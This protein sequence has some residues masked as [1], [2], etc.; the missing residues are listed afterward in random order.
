M[1]YR[2]L[3]A[4]E[5]V[6]KDGE[7][8]VRGAKLRTVLGLLVLH[9]NQPVSNDALVD[10]LW[11]DTPPPS[12]VTTLQTYIYQLRKTLG[13]D[14]IRTR[15]TGYSLEAAR[16]DVDALRFED[17]VR[18]VPP[19][20]DANPRDVAERLTEA[21]GW[22]RGSALADFDGAKWARAG[23]TQLDLLRLDATE[24]LI[25]ARLALGDHLA[26]A[27]ELEGLI[28]RNPLRERFYAQL[29]LAL[30]R[31]DRQADALRA[32]ARLNRLLRSELGL[33]PSRE[34]TTLE[35]AVLA[36]APELDLPSAPEVADQPPSREHRPPSRRGRRAALV[37][38][39]AVAA[40]AAVVSSV[41]I[42][43]DG[44]PNAAA[45]EPLGY[46]PRYHAIR[47][48]VALTPIDIR[49]DTSERCG[50]LTVPENRDRPHGRTIDLDVLR[51]PTRVAH[52]AAD[53]VVQVGA[54]IVANDQPS[55]PALRTRADSIYLAGRGFY[56]SKPQLTCTGVSI[57]MNASLAR[58]NRDPRI[59]AELARE[60]AR[61]HAR[62]TAAGV[63]LAA[64]SPAETAADVR[65]LALALHFRHI[66]V[67]AARTN[68]I[69]A[70][71]IAGRYPDLVR[72]ITLFDVV[73]PETNEWNGEIA[74]ASD[75]LD[76]F[77]GE[78][79]HQRACATAYPHL[80]QQ[81]V[82]L[83]RDNQASPQTFV[84]KNPFGSTP[85]RLSLVLDGDRMMRLVLDALTS[86]AAGLLPAALATRDS[87]AAAQDALYDLTSPDVSWG[88][89]LSRE[90]GSEIRTV[91]AAALSVEA[92]AA[93]N[94][95]FLA[96]DPTLHLCAHWTTAPRNTVAP[97]PVT[98]PTLIV[99]GAL[100]PFTSPSWAQET[101]RSF[102]TATIVELPHSGNAATTPDPCAVRIRSEFLAHPR[103][104]LPTDA[105]AHATAA[106]HFVGA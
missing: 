34:L 37:L 65:D 22:W 26:V 72:S 20:A 88:A 66:N 43:S 39:I 17:A 40:A 97:G 86:G 103:R 21:L 32:Y 79:R 74:N 101:A 11:G 100:D 105:C 96:A 53:P 60:V 42:H 89:I 8:Q 78:C 80:H 35:T 77:V 58:P 68:T 16:A 46:R 84:E 3:G 13:P 36:H 106:V 5:V 25:D 83:F 82:D 15:P 76:R 62:W 55:D 75:A 69:E 9:A 30:Y 71:E 51:F 94:L 70:R 85:A 2:I 38:A 93:P 91:S 14:A 98:A 73:P 45:T 67:V 18:A 50:V 81:L 49:P 99:F 28:V 27:A 12:V 63:D 41:V 92:K 29:M 1:E 104:A 44:R 87:E 6:T 7:V 19:E 52:P 23:A 102:G 47:C 10:A 95:A 64:Y 33:E 57:E 31:S 48:P 54:D 56:G 90:C 61:C 59:L 4:L 24:R